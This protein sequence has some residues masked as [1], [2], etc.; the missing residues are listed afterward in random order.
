M[1]GSLCRMKDLICSRE[2]LSQSE[3]R[4]RGLMVWGVNELIVI[5]RRYGELLEEWQTGRQKDMCQGG[6][7]QEDYAKLHNEVSRPLHHSPPSPSRLTHSF[8]LRSSEVNDPP[9]FSS[10]LV[11][12]ARN[13][14]VSQIGALL[15]V[16]SPR[17]PAL[18]HTSSQQNARHSLSLPLQHNQ[19]SSHHN[20]MGSSRSLR[21]HLRRS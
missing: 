6:K 2:G 21:S 9:R 12:W 19:F 16:F 13:A 7:W 8:T 5:E 3:F 1:L 18:T 4:R 14:E 15:L 17:Y 10:P 11:P 20:R